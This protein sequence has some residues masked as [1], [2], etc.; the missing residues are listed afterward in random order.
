MVRKFSDETLMLVRSMQLTQ[1]LDK[2]G[3]Q[4][5]FYWRCDTDF[6]PIKDMRTQRLYVSR[7]GAVW[8]LLVTGAK[9]W[10]A[11]A[12][13]GGGGGIDLVIHLAGLDFVNTVKLLTSDD[14]VADRL[15][16]I[17]RK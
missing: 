17:R 11:R 9:W 5:G 13:R 16:S 6:Q 12:G 3:M 15:R 14:Q 7:H 8:E 1:V 4:L 2:L 10:D